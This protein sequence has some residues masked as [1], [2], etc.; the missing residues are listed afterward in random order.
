MSHA[1]T[2]PHVDQLRLR[3]GLRLEYADQGP[4]DADTTLLLLHG[5]T[6][7]WRSFEPV[8]AHLPRAWRA[9][10]LTQ[11]GHGG[12]DKPPADYRARSFAADAAEF[13]RL[14][15]LPPVIVVGH[16]MGAANA[17][18]LAAD[19][20]SL[21]HGVVAAGAFAAFSD[22]TELAAFV[23]NAIEPLVEPVP[24][25]LAHQFQIDTLARPCA[26]AVLDVAIDESLRVPAAVWRAAFCDL[27]RDDPIA[28]ARHVAAPT[29]LVA[30][31]RDAFAP[32]ADAER[33]ARAIPGGRVS[34]WADAGHAMHWEEPA[35][36]ARELT[37]FVRGL[38]PA[39]Q[40]A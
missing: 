15:A 16:S 25:A 37:G 18:R 9:I 36:F 12:S 32:V 6:D 4:R 28:I 11:R 14:L 39:T 23:R 2:R 31:E 20:P 26:P 35:R 24:R 7:S 27:L 1:P 21:V 30:G 38:A 8:L 40:L 10:S 5:I 29:L 17:L 13:I 19:H 34:V 3:N 33:L 22:K